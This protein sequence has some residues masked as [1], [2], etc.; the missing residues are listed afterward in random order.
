[1]E[2][3]TK[4]TSVGKFV[5]SRGKIV[6]ER[7]RK[8]IRYQRNRITG[9]RWDGRIRGDG[10]S[11]PWLIGE[12]DYGGIDERGRERIIGFENSGVWIDS[13]AVSHRW[14]D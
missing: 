4:K 3:K 6:R 10:A 11:K 2:T 12:D 5:K 9:S 8:M 1:M 14:R 13:I 7:E